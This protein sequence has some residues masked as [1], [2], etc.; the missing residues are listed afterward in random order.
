VYILEKQMSKKYEMKTINTYD[1]AFKVG[2]KYIRALNQSAS[3]NQSAMQF[4]PPQ[5]ENPIWT[6]TVESLSNTLK[7]IFELLHHQ[8]YMLCIN[9]NNILMCKLDMQTTA[10]MFSQI[11]DK[12]LANLDTNGAITQAQRTY[13]RE[14]INKNKDRLRVM[15]CIVKPFSKEKEKEK[16]E[17][18]I[19]ENE[20]LKILKG[21]DLPNGVFILNLT[22][23]V[24]LRNHG[25]SPFAMVTGKVNLDADFVFDKHL[26]IL[27]IS[28]QRHY[29][30]IPIPNY[31][32]IMTVLKQKSVSTTNLKKQTLHQYK[33]TQANERWDTTNVQWN[34]GLITDWTKKKK[35][36]AVFRGGPTGC[37][38]TTET[39]MRLKLDSMKSSL[40][41]VR[42]TKQE[43]AQSIDT[44]SIR[45]DP[46]YGLG[47]MNTR[48]NYAN[49][50]LNMI[51][52]SD[53][54]YIIHVDGNVNAY[55]LLTTMTTG[56]LVLRVMSPYTS[57]ADHMM[58]AK[59]HYIPVKE[60]L[61][62][63][64]D[65]I[66]WCRRNDDRCKEI[67]N[68]GL[69]FARSILNKNYIQSYLS[70]ILWSLAPNQEKKQDIVDDNS[71]FFNK[72]KETEI[73]TNDEYIDMPANKSQCPKGY[74]SAL[75]EGKK[76]CK[77]TVKNNKKPDTTIG[78]MQ[79]KTTK[80]KTT[81]NKT[82]KVRFVEETTNEEK[83]EYIDIPEGK[84]QCPKG[85][86]AALNDGRK[87]CKKN[88]TLKN[89]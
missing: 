13:I 76:K 73:S 46:I 51:Q 35:N 83:E 40:L 4:M 12:H 67:A 85:Y 43:G 15:Q 68:N 3:Q 61:S 86:K 10:P 7:Y 66:K 64:L 18:V 78:K 89:M 19:N 82:K 42:L 36:K 25:K 70:Q 77:K 11:I 32:D 58:K 54:K 30:D 49:N 31:D 14:T 48:V 21:I 2:S 6:M 44:K 37:G 38:Y 47:V 71:V 24:I 57:W 26:P 53:F 16:E 34:N 5:I 65:V 80:E 22:D 74:K 72:E 45:F 23:A 20:Y 55:R 75:H 9:N 56:S 79:G 63:L 81:K 33:I 39:N 60:D 27:S 87:R 84:K 52:Q 28:G 69:T 29:L 8:C 59:V 62:D 50:F 41:D 88:T 17:G 1:E